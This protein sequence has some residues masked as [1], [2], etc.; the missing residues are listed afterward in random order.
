MLQVATRDEG[1]T[2]VVALFERC[3]Q[4]AKQGN[5]SGAAVVMADDVNGA[6]MRQY[7]GKPGL[8]FNF[9]FE[10]DELKAEVAAIIRG[11]LQKPAQY[12]GADYAIYPLRTAPHGYDFLAWLV[13]REMHRVREGAPAPLKVLLHDQLSNQ[14][15]HTKRMIYNVMRP[16]IAMI[17]AVEDSA[18][19]AARPSNI[20]TFRNVTAAVRK[21]EQVPRLGPSQAAVDLVAKTFGEDG[22]VTITLRET[23]LYPHRNSNLAEWLKVAG[24][25]QQQGERVVFVRDTVTAHEPIDGYETFPL[26]STDI[27]VRVALY[28]AARCNLFVSN[29]PATLAMF[30]RKP[31][32]MFCPVSEMDVC[33]ASR[34]QWWRENHGISDGE[35]LPW[36]DAKQRIIWK[37]D[38][39]ENIRDAWNGLASICLADVAA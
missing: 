35:Q 23:E 19:I 4:L 10:L 21:G 17:G 38:T 20:Y 2:E 11:P 37:A 32:L 8:E 6:M 15:E 25:L 7:S 29:G 13:D 26:A 18:A 33:Q 1:N 24:Y 14:T 27:D 34:P 12:L 31:L 22:I 9:Y 28:D 16:L 5:I 39:F 30:G 36:L 3:L